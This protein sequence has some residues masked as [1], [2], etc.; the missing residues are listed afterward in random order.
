MRDIAVGIWQ[1]ITGKN[2]HGGEEY[3]KHRRAAKRLRPKAHA[4]Y[5]LPHPIFGTMRDRV[6]KLGDGQEVYPASLRISLKPSIRHT[7][8]SDRR[9]RRYPSSPPEDLTLSFL[10]RRE[11]D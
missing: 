10:G 2:L 5:I 4:H 9:S 6:L 1:K 7:C 8:P 3:E 11:G